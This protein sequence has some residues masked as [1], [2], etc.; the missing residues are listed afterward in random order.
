M[1]E[2]EAT[3][4]LAGIGEQESSAE[5]T[6]NKAAERLAFRG[7]LEEL[8]QMAIVNQD[9]RDRLSRCYAINRVP[10]IKSKTLHDYLVANLSLSVSVKGTSREQV[11]EIGK[12]AMQ[13]VPMNLLQKMKGKLGFD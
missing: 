1:S 2:L 8:M 10:L 3:L 6:L 12:A 7:T 13:Q 4:G 11:L 9:E 5:K